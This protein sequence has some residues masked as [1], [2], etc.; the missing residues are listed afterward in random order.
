MAIDVFLEAA[1][2]LSCKNGISLGEAKVLVFVSQWQKTSGTKKVFPYEGAMCE[3]GWV[4]VIYVTASDMKNE[5]VQ[6]MFDCDYLKPRPVK[7]ED[8]TISYDKRWMRVSDGAENDVQKALIEV[9]A[10]MK[11]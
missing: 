7:K 10:M 5:D 6:N 11:R 8:G 9:E 3:N 2:I 4:N 1:K